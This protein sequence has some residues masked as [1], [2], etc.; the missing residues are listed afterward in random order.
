MKTNCDYITFEYTC[1]T[2][3]P[4]LNYLDKIILDKVMFN[5]LISYP[6]ALKHGEK[7]WEMMPDYSNTAEFGE[8]TK[9]PICNE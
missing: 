8:Q 3:S 2:M 1:N 4:H 9:W 5:S 7:F 6:Q